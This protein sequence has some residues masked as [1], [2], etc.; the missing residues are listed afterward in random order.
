[1]FLFNDNNLMNFSDGDNN[2]NR[3]IDSELMDLHAKK[4]YLLNMYKDI[5]KRKQDLLHQQQYL[6]KI[7][8]ENADLAS[9]GKVPIQS[10]NF[11]K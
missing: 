10:L 6:D 8:K 2:G 1:M 9:S 11:G 4:N 3:Q 5:N 7:K